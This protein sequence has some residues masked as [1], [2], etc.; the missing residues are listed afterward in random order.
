MTDIILPI[1]MFFNICSAGYVVVVS[2]SYLI[3]LFY[4]FMGLKK[5]KKRLD[6]S[7]SSRFIESENIVPISVLVPAFNEEATIVDTVK[8]LL[9]LDYPNYEIV[10]V[11][12]GST[13]E[14]LN[15]LIEEF[16]LVSINE[17]FKVS[18]KTENVRGVY[19][20]V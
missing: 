18:I 20:S 11:N 10:V 3:Q 12:D 16:N 6:Y 4:A 1:F 13:D 9:S 15:K 8:N 17:P 14:T 7:T 5:Y 19:R 2:V